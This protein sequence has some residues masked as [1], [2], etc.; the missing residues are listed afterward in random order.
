M[1]VDAIDRKINPLSI[2]QEDR[3]GILMRFL[4]KFVPCKQTGC[5]NWTH[6]KCQRGYGLF[7]VSTNRLVRANRVAHALFNGPL[8]GSEIVCHTCDNPSCVNPHHLYAGSFADNV[9]DREERGRS[10]RLKG[11]A[12]GSSKLTEADV[13]NIRKEYPIQSLIAL[14]KKYGVSRNTIWEI[15]TKRSWRHL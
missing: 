9:V 13:L 7:R 12:H 14:A 6:S 1:R 15:A 5:W 10:N 3:Q 8:F 2:R 4:L 11:E